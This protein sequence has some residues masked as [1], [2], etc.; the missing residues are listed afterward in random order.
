MMRT[1]WKGAISFGL[2]NVPVKL[3]TATERKTLKFHLLHQ[4]CLTPLEYQRH[5]PRCNRKVE[6]QEIV[7]GYEYEKGKYVVMRDEDFEQ[8][9]ADNTRTIDIVDFVDLKEID[10]V[11]FDKSYYL[12]SDESGVKAYTLL[13][14][15]M[16]ETGKI[17]IAKI[18][19]RSKESL[20]ALRVRDGV[21]LLETMYYPDEIR[22]LEGL[23]AL[24]KEV[25]IHD[26][27]IKMAISLI[28]NL[29]APFQPEKYN[30]A[31]RRALLEVI[32]AKVEGE[33]IAVPEK[34]TGGKVV[35]LM[36]ALK[37]S[38]E[39]AKKERETVEKDAKR[40]KSA[41]KRKRAQTS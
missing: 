30:D 21:M 33:E 40:L 36:E 16:E 13:I 35:N 18:V 20:A 12:T 37:A 27:E 5:C 17:A 1:L 6:S 28:N 19:I 31:Y 25:K 38:V 8:I 29:A 34:H 14:K 39:L 23:P 11:Y 4:E 41:V 24:P 22:P 15:A 10:P 7:K 3:Y 2:V 26:N 9:P 32:R